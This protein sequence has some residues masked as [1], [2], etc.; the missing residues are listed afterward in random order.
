[1]FIKIF[2]FQI[3]SLQIDFL[4][5]DDI[6]DVVIPQTVLQE[7][8]HRS[9]PVYKRLRDLIELPEK[10]FYVFTNEHHR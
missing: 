9:L 10:R 3:N 4:S 2:I 8:K 6:K 1:M 7:V 5:H